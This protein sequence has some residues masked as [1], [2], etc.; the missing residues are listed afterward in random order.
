MSVYRTIGP[1]VYAVQHSEYSIQLVLKCT[2]YHKNLIGIFNAISF[3][4]SFSTGSP[5]YLLLQEWQWHFGTIAIFLCW[6]E[7]VLFIQKFPM[8]GIYV[9]MFKNILNTFFKFFIVFLIFIIAFGMGFFC[10]LQ[11]QVRGQFW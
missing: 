11:N 7:F 9:V 3:I 6:L 1:L 4:S 8:F 2:L 5:V 10:L